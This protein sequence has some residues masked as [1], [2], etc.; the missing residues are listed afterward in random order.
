M[1]WWKIWKRIEAQWV[2][3]SSFNSI[4]LEMFNFSRRLRCKRARPPK[5]KGEKRDTT[6]NHVVMV[7]WTSCLSSHVSVSARMRLGHFG[8]CWRLW[9]QQRV[10]ICHERAFPGQI[11]APQYSVFA[12]ALRLTSLKHMKLFLRVDATT[13]RQ[14]FLL[15]VLNFHFSLRFFRH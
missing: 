3:C 13:G 2:V 14:I 15:L 5:R 4:W 8:F 6:I 12:S 1:L 9:C 10:K 11:E 7:S